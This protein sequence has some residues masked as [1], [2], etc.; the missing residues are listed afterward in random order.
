M[1]RNVFD[2]L[3]KSDLKAVRLVSRHWQFMVI[4]RLFDTCV[5]SPHVENIGCFITILRHSVYKNYV[6]RLI[7]DG[8]WF[9]DMQES[10]FRLKLNDQII[11]QRVPGVQ[12]PL[13]DAFVDRAFLFHGAQVR[14]QKIMMGDGVLIAA[15]NTGPKNLPRLKQIQVWSECHVGAPPIGLLQRSW[16]FKFLRTSSAAVTSTVAGQQA[17]R[18]QLPFMVVNTFIMD[19]LVA[20]EK[21]GQY[22]KSCRINP[23]LLRVFPLFPPEKVQYLTRV[24]QVMHGLDWLMA[25]KGPSAQRD[26]WVAAFSGPLQ[27]AGQL[28]ELRLEFRPHAVRFGVLFTARTWTHLAVLDLNRLTAIGLELVAFLLRHAESLEELTLRNIYLEIG[29]WKKVFDQ[30]RGH[31][32]LKHCFVSGLGELVD[33]VEQD[34]SKTCGEDPYGVARK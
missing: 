15:L 16:D 7:Y 26:I 5:I 8:T 25:N 21:Q 20:T 1:L 31:L 32:T 34:Y 12:L 24:F 17:F 10:E 4:E 27:A 33:G 3:P 29:S 11:H 9:R 22:F 30:T 18:D 13:N 14:Q 23:L 6:R 2:C 28:R 19:R